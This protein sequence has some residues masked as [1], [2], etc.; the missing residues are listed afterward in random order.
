MPPFPDPNRPFPPHMNGL[1]Q[2]FS[3]VQPENQAEKLKKVLIY[4][5]LF[6]LI[7]FFSLFMKFLN[8]FVIKR[9]LLYDILNIFLI[10]NVF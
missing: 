1:P 5:I 3:P 4:K 9:F 6:Y 2:H 7:N 8:V 10:I